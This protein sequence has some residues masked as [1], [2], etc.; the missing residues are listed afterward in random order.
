MRARLLSSEAR[1]GVADGR[2]QACVVLVGDAADAPL[3]LFRITLVEIFDDV[4]L[5][6]APSF[7]SET[8]DRIDVADGFERFA[9]QDKPLLLDLYDA[10]TRMRVG[11]K[12]VTPD[13][14]RR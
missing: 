12:G 1:G 11:L 4:K 3:D 6:V 14:A 10:A 13:G 8:V 9:H 2:A 5:D 7:G